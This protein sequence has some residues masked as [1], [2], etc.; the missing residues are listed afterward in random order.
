MKIETKRDI[1]VL[2]GVEDRTMFFDQNDFMVHIR[3]AFQAKRNPQRTV[4]RGR[5]HTVLTY[6]IF[7]ETLY[8]FD[9]S[10][11]TATG[12][13]VVFIPAGVDYTKESK[14]EHL[15]VLHLDWV[16]LS[17]DKRGIEVFYP[18]DPQQMQRAFEE[19]C[20]CWEGRAC[21][22]HAAC[23][24]RLY[25]ILEALCKENSSV[26][27]GHWAI[28][29]KG[30]AYLHKNFRDPSLR[31]KDAAAQCHVSEVYFRKLYREIYHCAPHEALN[32][33]RMQ[34]AC[35]MLESG[36][37]TVRQIAEASGFSDVKYFRTAFKTYFGFTCGD[38]RKGKTIDK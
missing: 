38:F 14:E 30:I 15:I 33:L 29:E 3:A 26:P 6:R 28:I 12:G 22:Y 27:N 5:L 9:G 36:E 13:S 19:I 11:V 7:G 18:R 32:Q 35:G 17:G 37:G 23:T 24:A 8:T 21:G 1:I 4:D 10:A 25:Q 34:H 20:D 16:D 2:T 31:I